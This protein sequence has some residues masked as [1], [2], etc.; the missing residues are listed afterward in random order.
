MNTDFKFNKPTLITLTG[1]TAS[2]KSYLLEKLVERGFAR[3]VSTTTRLPRKGEREGIDYF[4]ISEEESKKIE[5]LDGFAELVEFQGV[6]YGVTRHEFASKMTG[7]SPPIIIFTP[8]GLEQYGTLCKENGWG[9]F[10]VYVHV[11]EYKRI[12]RLNERTIQDLLENVQCSNDYKTTINNLVTQH[13]NR[14]LSITDVERRWSNVRLWDAI[15]P[16][17]DIEK[18]IENIRLGIKNK[19]F[20]RRQIN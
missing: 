14:I 17:D 11:V 6:R 9:M 7:E 18:A 1:P 12:A 13:T 4:F 5:A 3:I 8:D 10:T 19:N 16:G 20:R 2:G 15:V